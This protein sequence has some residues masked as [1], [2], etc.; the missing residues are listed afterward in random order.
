MLRKM[1]LAVGLSAACAASAV[2]AAHAD[3]A[4]IDG[5]EVWISTPDG[6]QKV[7]LTE[8]DGNWQD[9]TVSD[10]GYV[11]A[12]RYESNRNPYYGTFTV[13]DQQGQKLKQGPFDAKI[14]GG[15]LAMP[16][17]LQLT[18][19]AGLLLYGF[20]DY[21]YGYPVGTLTTGFYALPTNT[22][23]VSAGGPP[24][25]TAA[26]FP[27]LLSGDRVVGA[28]GD[29][30]VG[31]S[32]FAL[33]SS[34]FIPWPGIDTS[35]VG[36]ISAL[37]VSADGTRLAMSLRVSTSADELWMFPAPGAGQAPVEV[38]PG[39]PGA[40]KLPADAKPWHP[41]LSPDGTLVGWSDAGGVKLVAT[42]QPLPTPLD[43]ILSSPVVT[44]SATGKYPSIGPVSV[45]TIQA[46][47]SVASDSGTSSSSLGSSSSGSTGSSANPNAPVFGKTS[48]AKIAAL[49]SKSGATIE[50]SSPLAGKAKVA[51]TVAPSVVGRSGSKAITVASGK[52]TL[53]ATKKTK[54][55]LTATASGKSLKKKLKGK[56]ATLTV[57]VN[58]LATTK[59][60]KL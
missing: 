26:E 1:I 5:G 31:V 50:V 9:V 52:A 19:G 10:D 40:C 28:T 18:P 30:T 25:F 53:K 56:K 46:A 21:V 45:A 60:I 15:L 32:D 57:T 6:A 11:A 27:A 16:L 37:D 58:G 59:T 55:K 38:A 35:G 14:T 4:Y 47:R 34:T 17:G 54:V 2:P 23:I 29:Y 12:V 22:T 13:W 24:R 33:M 8:G 43:C 48:T 44:L 3:V 51:I 49:V 39:D 7:R 36:E 41:A 20:S 42:P